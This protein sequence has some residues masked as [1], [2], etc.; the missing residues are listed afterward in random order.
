MRVPRTIGLNRHWNQ[1][2]PGLDNLTRL[3]ALSC[4]VK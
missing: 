1:V 3:Q 4:I 2:F